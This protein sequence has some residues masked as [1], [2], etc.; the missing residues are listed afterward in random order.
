MRVI[1]LTAY[2]GLMLTLPFTSCVLINL[3]SKRSKRWAN[4][5]LDLIHNFQIYSGSFAIIET[6]VENSIPQIWLS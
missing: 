6:I 2:M 3:N 4:L 5:P 1:T